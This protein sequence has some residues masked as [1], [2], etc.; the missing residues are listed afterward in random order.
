MRTLNSLPDTAQ[1]PIFDELPAK[2]LARVRATSRAIRGQ[3]NMYDKS[4]FGIEK[5]YGHFFPTESEQ[6][7]F[8]K[9]QAQTEALVSGSTLV[10]VL[11]RENFVPSDLDVFLNHA[12]VM[13]LGQCI[14]ELG[15]EFDPLPTVIEGNRTKS[16]QQMAVFE[17][18]VVVELA[19]WKPNTGDIA[20]RYEGSAIAGVF[21][22]KKGE[23]KRIQLVATRSDP[24]EAI[25]GFHSTLVM[26][27]ATAT[28]L[29]ALYPATSFIDKQAIYLKDFSSSVIKAVKKYEQ[30]GW[31]TVDMISAEEAL[32]AKSERSFKVRWVGDSHS[33]ITKLADIP[34]FAVPVDA[35]KTLWVTSWHLYCPEPR[36]I[37]VMLN[38]LKSRSLQR[39]YTIVWE[40]ERAVWAH[41]CFQMLEEV[42]RWRLANRPPTHGSDGHPNTPALRPADHFAE[43]GS[44][45]ETL[46]QIEPVSQITSAD[47]EQYLY[48]NSQSYC[49]H[50]S[51]RNIS[52]VEDALVEY[53]QGLYPLF[54]CK[55]RTN[56]VLLQ[57][58]ADFSLARCYYKGLKDP[59]SY[60]TGHTLSVMMRHIECVQQLQQRELVKV[61]NLSLEH[62]K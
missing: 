52:D 58:Q 49:L 29:I 48:V 5:L 13:S 34:G 45:V 43:K 56:Q 17:E 50:R 22:F 27:I 12:N 28:H 4:T 24:I 42:I 6:T 35:Y 26:N 20:D 15:Y 61:S 18:A 55:F 59:D 40:V 14:K 41:P 38:K 3:L 47:K 30:R 16:V 54:D 19:T 39:T 33:W 37:R 36:S 1:S 53:L 44:E 2:D 11:S 25:L 9:K 21:N 31:E 60:P 23:Q 7:T 57:M 32:H 10:K 62:D 51:T 46:P 8:R